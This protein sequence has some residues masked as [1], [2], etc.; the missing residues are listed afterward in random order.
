MASGRIES[1]ADC[2]SAEERQQRLSVVLVSGLMWLV[3]IVAVIASMGIALVALLP[4]WLLQR[5]LAEY[6]VRRIQALGATVSETQLPEVHRAA[7]EV[8]TRFGQTSLPRIIVLGSGEVNAL[9]IRFA[10]KRVIV[11][12]SELLEGVLDNPA[13]LRFLLA[14]ECCHLVLGGSFRGGFEIYKPARYRQARELTCDNAG[15]V[16]A[17]DAAEARAVVRRLCVGNRLQTRLNEQAL[18][19]EARLIYSGF[20][21]WLLRRNL[22]HPPA[23]ARI[24]NIERFAAENAIRTPGEALRSAAGQA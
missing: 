17:G 16:A 5:V 6:Q 11:L 24:E 23:G 2:V 13:Q 19:G 14:H 3:L 4:A 20:S 15:T 1:F 10:R 8:M 9:A 21:G 12:L 7:T 18:K 22:S